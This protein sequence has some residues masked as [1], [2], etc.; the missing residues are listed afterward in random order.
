MTTAK[1]FQERIIQR[2]SED[3]EFRARLMSDPTAAVG[4]ELNVELPEELI[5]R[6]HEDGQDSVNLVLPP[7][8]QLDEED[9]D[10]ISGGTVPGE[11]QPWE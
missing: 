8:Q 1:D 7:K 3:D 2:A 11:E 5:V 10:A 6:V 4:E 9:L